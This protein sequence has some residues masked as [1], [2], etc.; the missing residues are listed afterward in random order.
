MKPLGRKPSPTT[1]RGLIKAQAI[2]PL[3][4]FLKRLGIGR[5]SLAALRRRGLQVR[6][7]GQRLFI[8]GAEA[9]GTLRKLWAEAD[10]T[11]AGGGVETIREGTVE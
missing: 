10:G 3:P 4:V 6:P 8:D 11:A 1:G 2:Y 7:I 9:L 5:H